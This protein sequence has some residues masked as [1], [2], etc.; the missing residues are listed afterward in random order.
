MENLVLP[1]RLQDKPTTAGNFTYMFR[2][3]VVHRN[4]GHQDKQNIHLYTRLE[5]QTKSQ[6]HQ[7]DCISTAAIP[8]HLSCGRDEL[9]TGSELRRL[10]DS[11]Y[12]QIKNITQFKGLVGL[13]YVSKLSQLTMSTLHMLRRKQRDKHNN[14]SDT[15]WDKD[16]K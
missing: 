9:M 4:N 6:R 10:P 1:K 11:C 13:H 7:H 16:N 15:S 8:S 12:M 5:S 3:I 14:C 2:A